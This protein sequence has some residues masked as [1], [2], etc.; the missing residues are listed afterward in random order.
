[1]VVKDYDTAY[2]YHGEN[3]E[4]VLD[5]ALSKYP[6]ESFYV[7]DKF[8]GQAPPDYMAQFAEQPARLQ[9][10][11]IDFYLLHGVTDLTV[12]DYEASGCI[13]YFEEQK[14]TG[15][16]KYWGFSFHG[17]PDCLRKLLEKYCWD[18]V[19]IQL[20][21]HD[22]Y[23]GTSKQQY[24]ILR[25]HGIPVMV[26]EPIHGGMLANLPEECLQL[27]PSQEVSPA[28]LYSVKNRSSLHQLPLLL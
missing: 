26:M 24:V 10:E 21:Y 20:N 23:Q 27:L 1:M 18:F 25:E 22:W 4:V 8:N 13:P 14:R 28:A 12:T 19:Q 3:S 2:I 17:T 15:K 6:R 9:T 11:Y 5:R 16:I 7:A